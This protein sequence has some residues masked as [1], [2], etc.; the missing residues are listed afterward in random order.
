MRMCKTWHTMKD[1]RVRPQ[2]R[3]RGKKGWSTKM[4]NGANHMKLEG[5]TVLADEPFDLLDG[6]KADAP[7]QSGI[8]GHDINCRCYVSYEMMNDAEF[9]ARR[10]NIFQGR[11]PY[12]KSRRSKKK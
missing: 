2:R 11:L 8:A 4:G 7:G 3:R 6:N 10:E 5:Q 1:E 9:F 12:W